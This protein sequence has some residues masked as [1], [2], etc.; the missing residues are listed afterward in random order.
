VHFVGLFFVFT[1]ENARSKKQNCV[2]TQ[3][4]KKLDTSNGLLRLI[5]SIFKKAGKLRN[6]SD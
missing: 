1:I 3:E 2:K 6:K 5:N 4:T